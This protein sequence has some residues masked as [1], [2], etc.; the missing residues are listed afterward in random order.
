[1]NLTRDN[2]HNMPPKK[3]IKRALNKT[4]LLAGIGV[5]LLG[6]MIASPALQAQDLQNALITAYETNPDLMAARANLRATDELLAQALG[7]KRPTLSAAIDA[8][9]SNNNHSSQRVN[10]TSETDKVGQLNI[11]QT[12]FNSGKSAAEIEAAE[13]AISAGR[14]ALLST[15]QDIF[16]AVA[17]AYLDVV[18]DQAILDL[19]KNNVTR[20]TRQ[21]EATNDRFEVGEV[22]RTDVGLASSRLAGAKSDEIAAQG[23][24]KIS[25]AAYERVVGIYPQDISANISDPMV[26]V[27]VPK[28]ADAVIEAAIEQN[29]NLI[30]Q[31]HA[32]RQAQYSASSAKADIMPRLSANGS[33]YHQRNAAGRGVETDGY[34]IGLNL[35]FPFYQGGITASRARSA[36]SAAVS[37][38]HSLNSVRR[39][40]IEAATSAWEN[41]NSS[42]AFIGALEEELDANRLT[43]EGIEQE[44]MVGSR[45]VLD[46]LDAEQ[47]VMDVEVDLVSAQRNFLLQKYQMAAAMGLFNSRSLTLGGESYDPNQHYLEVKNRLFG[48]D[49]GEERYEPPAGIIQE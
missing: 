28:D 13:S 23:Q 15:E 22:T 5:M 11:S 39:Q 33:L 31:R 44:A 30:Q 12:L 43:L 14:A 2:I 40:V 26:E 4:M 35:N 41:Y 17:N 47:D 45:T 38:M 1:M 34:S 42:L 27:D 21:L 3:G 48:L 19:R 8:T 9:Y 49:A 36:Q 46:I 16:V 24:L 6:N 37:S 10:D 25:Q 18:R 20:L 7:I 29:P 32:Y